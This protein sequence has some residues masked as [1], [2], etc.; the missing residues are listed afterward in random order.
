M[1]DMM[2]VLVLACVPLVVF[3]G[4]AGIVLRREVTLWRWR[5]GHPALMPLRLAVPQKKTPRLA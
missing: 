1:A 5:H 4:A 3:A 2:I